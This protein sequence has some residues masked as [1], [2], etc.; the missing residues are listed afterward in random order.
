MVS[1]EIITLI[2]ERLSSYFK[3]LKEDDLIK[4]AIEL[5]KDS[6]LFG[7]IER[8]DQILINNYDNLKMALQKHE[9][10]SIAEL[11][12]DTLNKNA[13]LSILLTEEE[14]ENNKQELKPE[15]IESE[16]VLSDKQSVV[17]E[18]LKAH[19]QKPQVL[20]VV[21]GFFEKGLGTRAILVSTNRSYTQLELLD[22]YK[23]LVENKFLISNR[24]AGTKAGE[25]KWSN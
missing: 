17:N 20:D 2:K 10:L 12:T 11:L 13:G 4:L 24:R 14:T 23:L 7:K 18:Y 19:P 21:Y 1:Q 25:K 15:P 22:A 8:R 16:Q 6:N 9:K 5:V 3:S